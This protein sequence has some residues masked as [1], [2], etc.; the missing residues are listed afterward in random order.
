MNS[1]DAKI[2]QCQLETALDERKYSDLEEGRRICNEIVDLK[3]S[4]KSN[5]PI[6]REIK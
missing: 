6:I 1:I 5:L 3:R 2:R 4:F